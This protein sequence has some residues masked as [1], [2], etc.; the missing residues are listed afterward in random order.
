MDRKK[1]STAFEIVLEE[2]ESVVNGL[3]QDGAG[4]FQKGDY[5]SARGLIENATKLT[6]F[7]GKVLALQK[8]WGNLFGTTIPRRPIRRKST[9]KLKRGFRTPD[10][11]FCRP[12]L[13]T[14]MELG[15]AGRVNKVLDRIGEKMK[16]ILN[17]YDHQHLLSGRHGIRWRNTAQWCRNS[18]LQE[19]LLKGGS[20]RGI[21]EIS[22]RGKAAL[23][24]GAI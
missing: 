19:G 23:K 21:W 6:E 14:L 11:A 9:T 18:M 3:N 2:V 1:V 10:G 12:I 17:E 20:A 4:A 7:R 5:E 8:D 15:G 24:E 16:P 13:E 22:D